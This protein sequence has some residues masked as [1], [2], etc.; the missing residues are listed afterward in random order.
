MSRWILA[1]DTTTEYGSL[2]L[3][4]DDE[5]VEEV[6]V[7]APKGFAHVLYGHLAELFNRHLLKP[8]DI[9]LFAAAPGPGSFTGVRVGLTCVK[10]LAEAVGR[11]AVGISNLQAIASCGTAPLRAAVL[12]ARRGEVYAAVYDAASRLVTPEVVAS[13]EQWKA[14]L[15]EGDIEFVAAPRGLAGAIARLASR[16]EPQDPAAL[17]AN[18]VRRSDA[19]LLWKE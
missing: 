4:R 19:E 15:P 12:D 18:Y 8:A 10:G 3:L 5:L 17:D 6:L 13:F 9:D 1:V 11:P 2:A 14:T 16:A 7:H